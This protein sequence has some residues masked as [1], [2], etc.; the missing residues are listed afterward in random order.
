MPRDGHDREAARSKSSRKESSD[1]AALD[2][3]TRVIGKLGGLLQDW[4]HN[5]PAGDAVK[6]GYLHQYYNTPAEPGSTRSY[7]LALRMARAGHEVHVITTRYRDKGRPPRSWATTVEDGVIVHRVQLPYGNQMNFGQRIISFATFSLLASVRVLSVKPTLI[8]A[9]STPLTIA[10]PALIARALRRVP[11]VFEV[12][13]AWPELP[14][15]LGM[16]RN[17]VLIALAKLLELLAYRSSSRVIVLSAGMGTSVQR[18]G[19]PADRIT[20]IPNACDS[21]RFSPDVSDAEHWYRLHPEFRGRRVVA[22]AG[23]I[24]YIHGTRWIVDLAL[25]CGRQDPDLAF[26]LAGEG[27]EVDAVADYAR[28][29]GVLGVN[30]FMLGAIPKAEMGHY[31]AASVAGLSTTI[32]VPELEANSANKFFDYLA[33][34]KPTFVNYGGW[35]QEVLER[36]GAGARLQFE[37]SE[38]ASAQLLEFLN[39]PERME[40]ARGAAGELARSAYDRDIL[41]AELIQVLEA[42]VA[43]RTAEGLGRGSS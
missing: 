38:K 20:I 4:R 33:A 28:R 16:L 22:Y 3:R 2:C 9:S 39:S 8:F 12:R 7:E 24:G 11:M 18:V 35:Q 36:S 42:V 15:A 29:Q 32:R 13:D 43:E 27:R 14:I 25:A 26:T 21:Q 40:E 34:C 5:E 10:I 37:D 31:L 1:V 30:F 19:Y 41:A 23:T 17:P 6:I